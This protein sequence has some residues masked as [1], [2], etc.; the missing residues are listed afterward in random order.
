MESQQRLQLLEQVF[1]GNWPRTPD[2]FIEIPTEMFVSK[3]DLK[4]PSLPRVGFYLMKAGKPEV[5]RKPEQPYSA[6]ALSAHPTIWVKESDFGLMRDYAQAQMI[7]TAKIQAIPAQKRMETLRKAAILIVDD[8]FKEPT[9]KNINKGIHAVNN[10]VYVMMRD[11]NAFMLLARLGSHDPY[12]VQHSVGTAVNAIILAR[13][14]G[15]TDER[16]LEE[17][18]I[19]GLLHDIGK[20]HVKKEI[21]NKPGPLDETEW[22]EMRQHSALGYEIVKNNPNISERTKRAILEHHEDRNGTGYPHGKAFKD[23]DV[24]SKI[25]A[26]SDIYNALT[27]NRSYSRAM[28]PFEAFQLMREK[29][30]NKIDE[31]LFRNLVLIYG[32]KIEDLK[33]A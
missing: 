4:M 24:L 12:T 5:L 29:M 19:A 32:G 1:S 20:V 33:Q 8:I 25:V 10:F 22:E 7:E 3:V 18:G 30:L 13:K 9:E 6:L 14:S 15:I 28:A 2:G 16:V 31:E 23:V 17:A 26:I 27:T 21:I 11:P